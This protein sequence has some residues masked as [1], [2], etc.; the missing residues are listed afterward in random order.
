MN[1]VSSRIF[2]VVPMSEK[3]TEVEDRKTIYRT[4][5]DGNLEDPLE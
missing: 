3:Q 4:E 1:Q 5:D 2:F